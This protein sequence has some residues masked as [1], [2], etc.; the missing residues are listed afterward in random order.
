MADGTTLA[1][2]SQPQACRI[3]AHGRRAGRAGCATRKTTSFVRGPDRN[4]VILTFPYKARDYA[5]VMT[6]VEHA[7]Q[8]LAEKLRVSKK[9]KG[10]DSLKGERAHE[11]ID[12]ILRYSR[13]WV[14]R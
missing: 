13:W 8:S 2:G 7:I 4:A 3:V 5:T 11:T 6:H 10:E 9:L 14:A 12:S 1:L